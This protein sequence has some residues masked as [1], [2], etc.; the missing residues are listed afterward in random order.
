M[1][2]ERIEANMKHHTNGSQ[3]TRISLLEQ[4]TQHMNENLYTLI[5]EVK[6]LSNNMDSKLDNI[7]RDIKIFKEETLSRFERMNEKI[8]KSFLLINDKMDKRFEFTDSKI[9]RLRDKMDSTTKWL[10]GIGISVLFS[11]A[12]VGFSM[13]QILHKL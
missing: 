2:A 10:V 12:S 8:E 1:K 9:E 11:A 6:N 7:N 13:Y 4:S 5:G 3:E